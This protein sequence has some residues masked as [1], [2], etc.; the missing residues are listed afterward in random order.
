MIEGVADLEA[1][2]REKQLEVEHALKQEEL[3]RIS[4]AL[5]FKGQKIKPVDLAAYFNQFGG[6]FEQRRI[7]NLI[8]SVY[9]ISKTEI[10][11]FIQR[12]KKNFFKKTELALKDGA[13]T[14]YREN[15]ELYS[16]SRTIKENADIIESFK[17]L[18]FIR[19]TKTLKNIY[20][21]KDAWKN[22]G[23]DDII[24]FEGVVDT[25]SDIQSELLG[26]LTDEKI[27]NGKIP[28]KLVVLLI[29]TKAK[30]DLIKATAT[31]ANFKLIH[32]KEIEESKIKP[33]IDTTE[34]FETQDE[35][36][37]AFAEVRKHFH[38]TSKESLNV[39]FE[40]HCPSKTIPILWH[41]TKQFKSIFLNSYGTLYQELKE[42]NGELYRDRVYHATKQ[43]IQAI[44][45]Y[46]INHLKAKAESDG[47]K[48]EENWFRTPY[49]STAVVKGITEKWLS[50]NCQ[51]PKET[52]FD[53][54][55]YKE[56]V[57][58]NKELLPVFQIYDK[59]GGGNGLEWF[60][61]INEIRRSAA[62]QEKPPPT[63]EDTE[64]FEQ[65]KEEVLKRISSI[66][67]TLQP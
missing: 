57:K 49:V 65:K 13:K 12:E 50:E 9:Y 38:L 5:P 60:D 39:L 29:T 34:V 51:D 33:F 1:L 14:P 8:D 21:N 52:Y 63:L 2:Q 22:S 44:N 15:V 19:T 58:S 62:H 24:I 43:F 11:D 66:K 56:V 18:T 54:I 46:L 36:S 27:I 26:F 35:A 53:L 47:I 61:R 28:V 30:A 67:V 45:P 16:F 6:P 31:Y 55:H 37:Y 41:S 48:G 10:T 3:Q 17:R 25:F 23:S 40:S 4:D 59:K 7:F 20:E 64:Y 42:N 32:F